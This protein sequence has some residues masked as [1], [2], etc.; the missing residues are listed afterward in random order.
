MGEPV[1]GSAVDEI[2]ERLEIADVVAAYV[3]LKQSGRNFKGL[4]PFHSEK[5]PSFYV[6]PETGTWKCFGCGEGGDAFSFV[7]KRDNL[8][9]GDVLRELANR[10]GVS[11]ARPDEPASQKEAHE[12]PYKY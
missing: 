7:M 9:F 8:E 11:L 5:T 2:K 12:R 3:P 4:C 1:A 6:F 10:A